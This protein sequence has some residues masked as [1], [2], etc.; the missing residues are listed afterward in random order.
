[1]IYAV[2]D[3]LVSVA[4]AF[5]YWLSALRRRGGNDRLAWYR[6]RKRPQ[7]VSF[8]WDRQHV[9]W[10]HGVSAGEVKTAGKLAEAFRRL[11]LELKIIISSS[12][13]A[14]YSKAQSLVEGH[15]AVVMPLDNR[16]LLR[17]L[18]SQI[19]PAVL[20]IIESEFW[21]QLFYVARERNVPII[22]ANAN[23]SKKTFSNLKR[24][25]WLRRATVLVVEHF[26][27][28]QSLTSDRL[29]E[30]GVGNE[31][32]TVTGNMKLSP[33]I[34]ESMLQA[35]SILPSADDAVARTVTFANLHPEET[36]GAAGVVH[37]LR[38]SFDDIRIIV[39]PRHFSKFTEKDVIQAFGREIKI[40]QTASEVLP[41]DRYIW[42]AKMGILD[43][44]YAQT[45]IAVVFG[46]F[47]SVG[48]HDLV[49]PMHFGAVTVY[50]PNVERQSAL[51]A[52]ICKRLPWAQVGSFDELSQS[53]HEILQSQAILN[54]RRDNLREAL[55]QF[56]GITDKIAE[57]ILI[58]LGLMQ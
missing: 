42:F 18:F 28:Q 23:L 7:Q 27:A 56:S 54:A 58:D 35:R 37:K 57:H 6:A 36:D 17:T 25:G 49:E 52:E 53:L 3:V 44:V 5:Y 10:I 38:E 29:L 1:M 55:R 24:F 13:A 45:D 9:I 15:A 31:R 40:V 46:T 12:T 51:H 39:V 33:P 32:V 11:P 19:R 47:C 22:V 21:P 14:G 4:S 8:P 20:I 43:A 50:G 34:G 26:Y 48:G 30:L 2:Y 41:S 16:Q